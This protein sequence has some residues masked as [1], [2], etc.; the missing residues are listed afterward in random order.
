[1]D[2]YSLIYNKISKLTNKERD[3]FI[4]KYFIIDCANGYIGGVKY[5]LT[6]YDLNYELI[7][8][9]FYKACIYGKLEIIKLIESYYTVYHHNFSHYISSSVCNTGNFDTTLYL[10]SI[11]KKLGLT[12]DVLL[13]LTRA[14]INENLKVV[15]YILDNYKDIELSETIFYHAAKYPAIL[16]KLKSHFPVI[17]EKLPHHIIIKYL[18][19]K[20]SHEEARAYLEKLG[21]VYQQQDVFKQTVYHIFSYG[22]LSLIKYIL[23]ESI[24]N[25]LLIIEYLCYLLLVYNK[26]VGLKE[27]SE[28]ISLKFPD[29]HID[30]DFILSTISGKDNSIE[31]FE[32]MITNFPDKINISRAVSF[33]IDSFRNDIEINIHTNRYK[34]IPYL[35]K[36]KYI[37]YSDVYNNNNLFYYIDCDLDK[38]YIY[39]L[40]VNLP[41]MRKIV[42]CNIYMLKYSYKKNIIKFAVN[43]DIYNYLSEF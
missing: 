37:S 22:N 38:P 20:G 31:I 35:I 24:F 8:R 18:C 6:K 5:L 10:I 25:V 33:I 2:T 29:K 9:G 27:V 16:D 13:V 32:Y 43:K 17:Y 12:I 4:D 3:D 34:L 7:E 19:C 39:D 41:D 15:C 1:M 28:Y 40:V 14:C 21:S 23:N 36:N 30:L 26:S 42:Y 11:S